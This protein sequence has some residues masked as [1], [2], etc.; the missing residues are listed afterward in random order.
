MLVKIIGIKG[1]DFWVNPDHVV[2]VSDRMAMDDN[3]GATEIM[4]SVGLVII[5][6][7]SVEDAVRIV[8][9]EGIGGE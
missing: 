2:S 5:V 6:Q 9:N 1:N 3:K 4:M 8:M 7:G